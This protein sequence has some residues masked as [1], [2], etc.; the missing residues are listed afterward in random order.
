MNAESKSC[1]G[2]GL[3]L[4]KVGVIASLLTIFPFLVV[5]AIT[6]GAGLLIVYW[7]MA[8]FYLFL[9][10]FIFSNL[11]LKRRDKLLL[12]AYYF[13]LGSAIYLIPS[14]FPGFRFLM[15]IIMN[16]VIAYLWVLVSVRLHDTA[17]AMYYCPH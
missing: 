8:L 1:E 16:G 2:E 15:G 4:T 12:F 6:L 3:S 10:C 13:A 9:D 17:K 11:N 14:D 7:G 5:D